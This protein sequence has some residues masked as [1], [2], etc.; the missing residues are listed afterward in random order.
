[1]SGPCPAIGSPRIPLTGTRQWRTNIVT[2]LR[3]SFPKQYVRQ[4]WAGEEYLGKIC[5][6]I[7]GRCVGSF[8]APG[9]PPGRA[10]GHPG[11][12]SQRTDNLG[13]AHSA[14]GSGPYNFD[15]HGAHAGGANRGRLSPGWR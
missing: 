2:H 6:E 3:A 5:S 7:Q 9:D 14:A 4:L 11:A 10:R 8:A 13:S 1:M 15:T 12:V